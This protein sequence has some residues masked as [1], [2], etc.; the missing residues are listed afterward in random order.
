VWVLTRTREALFHGISNPVEQKIL[1]PVQQKVSNPVQQKVSNPVQRDVYAFTK[2]E[3]FLTT[4][5]HK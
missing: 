2:I 3:A 1:N 5:S 4:P